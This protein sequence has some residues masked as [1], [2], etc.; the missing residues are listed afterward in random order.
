MV[1]WYDRKVQRVAAFR[2]IMTARRVQPSTA[3]RVQVWRPQVALERDLLR[4][5]AAPFDLDVS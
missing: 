2:G 3:H 4:L 5:T 1:R